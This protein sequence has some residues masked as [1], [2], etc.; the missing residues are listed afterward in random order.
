M[1][2]LEHK[3]N[4]KKPIWILYIVALTAVVFASFALFQHFAARNQLESNGGEKTTEINGSTTE[5]GGKTGQ[6]TDSGKQTGTQKTEDVST[7]RQALLEKAAKLAAGYYYDE[8]VT[9]L[10]SDQALVNDETKAKAD[11][12]QKQK[13]SLVLYE[14]QA[15]HVF[16]HSLIVYPELAFDKKGAPADGYNMWMT[17]V[18]EFQK[19]L[20]LLMKNN[21]VLYDITQLVQKDANGK[22]TKKDIYLP[23]GK[24]PLIISQDDV[25]YYDY[26]A[27]D[28]FASK[29]LINDKGDVVTQV[30]APDGTISNTY[31]GDVVP[32]LD[33][34]V[35]ENP[36]FSFRGAK[37][38]VAP[39]GFQ[40]AFGYRITDPDLYSKEVFQQMCNDVKAVSKRLRETGWQIA[41]HSYTHNSYWNAINKDQAESDM[42]RWESL[43]VPYV[44]KTTILITPFGGHFKVGDP[45][46]QYI[47]KQLGYTIICPVGSGMSTTYNS[48]CMMQDR[49][50]LDGYTMIKHPERIS[51]YFF[52]PALVLDPSRP[53]LNADD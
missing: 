13:D 30:K 16:F 22:V 50:D 36:S 46:Y 34:F 23:K 41:S 31:T 8:A 20:P 5:T 40:G 33:Q 37:G 6:T 45:A 17:T 4:R 15:Y 32:I 44:G 18:S 52:D 7:K 38:I 26:M 25:S 43:M 2:H 11:E 42:S 21:F 47:V 3:H 14:G 49:L 53:P 19:M 12:Y 1:K 35:K 24:K 48:D 29:L 10:S 9:L 27:P 39:T 51:K 28:G